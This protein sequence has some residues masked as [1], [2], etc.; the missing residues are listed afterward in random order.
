MVKLTEAQVLARAR[1]SSRTAI[2]DLASV[3]NLNLW[4]QNLSDVSILQRLPNL[5]VL[6]LAINSLTTLTSFK[7]LNNLVELY[8]R[9]NNISDIREVQHIRHLPKLRVLWLSENP[10]ADDPDYR[11]KTI[12]LLP[13]LRKLDDRD[14]TERERSEAKAFGGVGDFA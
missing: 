4:G 8:L 3:R 12:A 2:T 14:V 13:Q 9:R 5:E 1:G 11:K 10:L 6:S 7:N